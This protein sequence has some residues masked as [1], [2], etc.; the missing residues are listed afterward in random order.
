MPR[1]WR[2]GRYQLFA[3][4]DAARLDNGE[5]IP[6]AQVRK[7]A[8][9]SGIIPILLGSR[10]QI[11]DVGRRTRTINAGLRRILVARDKA[12]PT[13]AA[14]DHPNTPKRTTSGHGPTEAKPTSTTS[15]CSASYA[16]VGIMPAPS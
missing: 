4:L 16:D 14:P 9:D 13:P 6:M 5:R 7:I 12:A 10:S 1:Q 2:G 8:C 11:Y 3:D 15:S